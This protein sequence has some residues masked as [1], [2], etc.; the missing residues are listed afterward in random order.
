MKPS[1]KEK[2]YFAFAET[3]TWLYV[4]IFR[5]FSFLTILS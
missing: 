4:K 5:D 3:I 1:S 2:T